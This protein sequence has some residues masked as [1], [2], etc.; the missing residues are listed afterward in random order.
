MCLFSHIK[1]IRFTFTV[2]DFNWNH[3]LSPSIYIKIIGVRIHSGAIHLYPP[4]ESA[5]ELV[6]VMNCIDTKDVLFEKI[7]SGLLTKAESFSIGE[8]LAR[9][10]KSVQTRPH[11]AQTY[12][13]VFGSR[14]QDVGDWIKSVPLHIP[15]E[16]SERY[17][18]FLDSFREKHRAWFETDLTNGVTTDGDFHSHNAI[19]SNGSLQL[20]DTFPPKEEWSV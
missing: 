6:I 17:L 5:D 12:Y 14:I 18:H 11:D 9:M 8:Q 7:M 19:F 2:R 4:D 15:Q 13:Q 20:M 10:L 16:E 3:A 1:S